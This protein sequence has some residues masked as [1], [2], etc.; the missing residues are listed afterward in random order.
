[1]QSLLYVISRKLI[2]SGANPAADTILGV[3]NDQFIG[4]TIEEAFP[5]LKATEVPK[6]FRNAA[7]KG[8]SWY[9]E[10]ISYEDNQIKGIFEVHAFQTSQNQMTAVFLEISKR[11]LADEQIQKDLNEKEVLLK[12]IHHRVKNNLQIICSLLNLQSQHITDKDALI[13]FEESR[14]RVQSMALVH[15]QLY[16]SKDFSRIDFSGYIK[17]LANGLFVAYSTDPG[18]I[19]LKLNVEKV[20]LGIDLAVPCGLIINELISNA[21]KHAFPLSYKDKGKIEINL[22]QSERNEIELTVT[23]NGVGL[24][25]DLEFKEAKSLGLKLIRILVEN[26][27]DGVINVD[28]KKGTKYHIIYK[29]K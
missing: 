9:T 3:N 28:R 4:K 20:L 24:P 16:Q 15:E 25:K 7:L 6:R 2:F 12:E 26:Q 1:M 21:L 27:L 18:R 29:D 19:E 8:E 22:C 10:Q 11:K 13:K 23:D 17:N 5:P 14:T